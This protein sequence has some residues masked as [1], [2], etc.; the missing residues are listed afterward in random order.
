MSHHALPQ[1]SAV[2]HEQRPKSRNPSPRHRLHK[3]NNLVRLASEV[4][5][6]GLLLGGLVTTISLIPMIVLD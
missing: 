2:H 6:A 3:S 5:C 4:V 1:R